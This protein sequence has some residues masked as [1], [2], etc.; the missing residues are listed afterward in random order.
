M[1]LVASI[2]ICSAIASGTGCNFA[3]KHPSTTAGI[4]VGALGLATCSLTTSIGEDG[5]S[6]V[7]S[8]RFKCYEVVALA[9][10]GIGAITALALWLGYED[11][12][13]PAQ[14]GSAGTIQDPANLEPAPVFVPKEP[15][16]P[17]PEPE[18]KPEPPKDPPPSEPQPGE[19]PA[20]P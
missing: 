7:D 1:R 17:K 13:A 20:V 5:V 12:D 2:A 10:V 16:K 3:V 14:S 15:V 9:A 19:P 11:E 18:P 8:Q 6:F 4:V